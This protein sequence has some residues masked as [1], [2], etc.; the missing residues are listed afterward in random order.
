MHRRAVAAVP[1][2]EL[3]RVRLGVGDE[4]ALG[5]RRQRRVADDHE[6]NRREHGHGFE[7]LQRIERQLRVEADVGR[8][9]SGGAD[10]ERVAVG[11]GLGHQGQ[12]DVAAGA[13]P[14][15]DDDLLAQAFIEARHQHADHG[16]GASAWRKGDDH[17]DRLV[18]KATALCLGRRV[19]E[20]RNRQQGGG[21][22]RQQL[23]RRSSNTVQSRSGRSIRRDASR[24]VR[25]NLDQV[26]GAA[27]V[28]LKIVDE[29][30]FMASLMWMLSSGLGVSIV[31]SALVVSAH[32]D[33]WSPG[34]WRW[35]VS[36][37]PSRS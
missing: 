11:R 7:I 33:P 3:A 21:T 4:L 29:V 34:R 1:D 23:H 13:R 18:G 36:R 25:R 19:G 35:R 32:F 12:A 27:R 20:P 14:V 6:R 24:W 5:L 37:A 16:V 15:V 31:P 10:T 17:A 28:E 30:N 26:A 8:K 22:S 2:R 9:R